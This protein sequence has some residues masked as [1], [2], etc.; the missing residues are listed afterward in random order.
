MKKIILVIFII[1]TLVVIYATIT[2]ILN[3][4]DEKMLYQKT[5]G[6]SSMFSTL[7]KDVQSNPA[8]NNP[9][10]VAKK[11]R[12]MIK[13]YD[14][15]KPV[16]IVDIVKQMGF[17]IK[18]ADTLPN[19]DSGIILIDPELNDIIGNSKCVLI[20]QKIKYGKRRF[21]LAHEIGHYLFEFDGIN[22]SRYVHS[23]VRSYNKTSASDPTEHK[24]NKFAAELLM[25]AEIF[26]TEYKKLKNSKDL[27]STDII[28][29]LS[30]FFETT[31]KSVEMR[32]IE[33][34]L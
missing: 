15:T 4:N 5:G 22:E 28:V 9:I 26:E 10:D 31:T 27:G 1:L 17:A 30:T 18:I 29:T 14:P 25:P 6:V 21:V 33:L 3:K 2:R 19:D 24:V 20:N 23:F 11:L 7:I 16:P 32:I 8:S 13:D 12:N 34:C